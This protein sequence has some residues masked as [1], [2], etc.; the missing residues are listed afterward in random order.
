MRAQRLQADAA[1]APAAL[2]NA[3]VP[4][5]RWPQEHWPWSR[6]GL[7]AIESSDCPVR[8]ITFDTGDCRVFPSKSPVTSVPHPPAAAAV[9]DQ[10]HRSPGTPV[11]NHQCLD[12]RKITHLW[13]VM[14]TDSQGTL[15]PPSPAHSPRPWYLRPRLPLT[16]RISDLPEA[17]FLLKSLCSPSMILTPT[18]SAPWVPGDVYLTAIR[19]LPGPHVHC[20]GSSPL[21]SSAQTTGRRARARVPA[22]A[23]R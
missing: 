13:V 1:P 2:S 16:S 10:P 21:S 4:R 20:P 14:A 12:P 18:V 15:M 19:L 7:L 3:S 23:L 8:V 6:R 5:L 9:G 17:T 22:G 11:S